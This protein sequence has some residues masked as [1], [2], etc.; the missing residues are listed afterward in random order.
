MIMFCPVVFTLVKN[1]ARSRGARLI[2]IE[3]T[4]RFFLFQLKTTCTRPFHCLSKG[5]LTKLSSV[6]NQIS[7][8]L[9]E[10]RFINECATQR[11]VF[12]NNQKQKNSLRMGGRLVEM[13]KV[14]LLKLLTPSTTLF[15]NQVK[16]KPGL[17]QKELKVFAVPKQQNEMEILVQ[18]KIRTKL[19]FK[20]I[21]IVFFHQCC[22]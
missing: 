9:I 7:V 17:N 15:Q 13:V 5:E 8:I 3:Q 10:C 2:A 16:T 6:S 22:S 20:H 12:F 21:A 19:A 4:L 14:A 18:K 11:K 1:M